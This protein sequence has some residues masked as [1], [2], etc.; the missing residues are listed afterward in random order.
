MF[1]IQGFI[2][3]QNVVNLLF[4]FLINILLAVFEKKK[5]MLENKI[6]TKTT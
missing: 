3:D 6:M 2:V 4:V 5:S 1:T